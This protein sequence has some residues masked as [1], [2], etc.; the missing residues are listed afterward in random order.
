MAAVLAG[1]GDPDPPRCQAIGDPEDAAVWAA[2]GA[3]A[4]GA[5]ELVQ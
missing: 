4:L 5:E 1:V 3:E 2:V